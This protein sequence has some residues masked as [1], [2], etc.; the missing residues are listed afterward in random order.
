MSFILVDCIPSIVRRS[1]PASTPT[2]KHRKVLTNP[3]DSK[4]AEEV[5]I[6]F[7]TLT[8]PP[9]ALKVGHVMK[10]TPIPIKLREYPE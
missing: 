10:H 5:N 3:D 1:I 8:S 6:L 9:L 7:P 2:L 4:V